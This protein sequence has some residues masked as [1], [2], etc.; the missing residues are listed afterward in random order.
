VG[1]GALVIEALVLLL[2]IVPLAR[3]GGRLAGPALVSILVL[4]V[5]CVAVAGM[6][7]RPWAWHAGTVLQVILLAS[8]VFHVALAVLGLI[9]G[10]AWLYLLS[11]RR[12]ILGSR[13]T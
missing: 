11:V 1:A 6:L 8:G 5:L 3:F 12:S 9:F 2:A 13:T 4:V 7:R 10:A